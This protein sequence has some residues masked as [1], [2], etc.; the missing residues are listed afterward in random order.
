MGHHGALCAQCWK[1]V[2]LIDDPV[3]A[4]T[5]MPFAH[6][7]GEGIVSAE[8]IADP[9]DYAMARA[10]AV[11]M[12]TAR[13]LVSRLKY[14]DHLLLA[15]LMARWM[16]RA[17]SPMIEDTNILMPIPLHWRRFLKRRYNQAAELAR[18]I[19]KLTDLEIDTTSLVRKRATRPQVGLTATA[20]EANVSGSFLVRDGHQINVQGR[21]VMLVDDVYTTGATVNAAARALKR[22]KADKVYVLTFSRVVPDMI[23]PIKPPRKAFPALHERL[24][25]RT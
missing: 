2:V 7:F 6:D 10:A 8:A 1:D 21:R 18:N 5:G 17:G 15:P 14:N 25:P 24:Y 23:E 16:V 4:L 3:C 19:G 20:R 11:H 9:P 13:Q 12:G 22:A